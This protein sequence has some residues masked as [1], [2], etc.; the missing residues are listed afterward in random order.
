MKTNQPPANAQI[1]EEPAIDFS[2]RDF[3]IENKGQTYHCTRVI[4][5]TGV[6]RLMHQAIRVTGTSKQADD[7]RGYNQEDPN[8]ASAMDEAARAIARQII[9]AAERGKG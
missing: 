6:H 1:G 2:R 8:S 3:T 7:P 5:T 4:T 9:E